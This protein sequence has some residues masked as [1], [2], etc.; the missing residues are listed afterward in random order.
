MLPSVS[1]LNNQILALQPVGVEVTGITNLVNVIATYLN[2]MQ[3]GPTGAPGIFTYNNAAAIA[4]L[5]SLPNVA[6]NSWITPFANGIHAGTT[7]AILVP[8]TITSPAWTV[9]AVDIGPVS[10]PTLSAALSALEGA[11][12]SVTSSND[13]AMPLAQAINIYALAFTFLTIGISGTIV[14]PV[15]LPLT[16]PAQ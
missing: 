1:S 8:G 6:D 5:E 10:I 14:S 2:Q 13:P 7:A 11:L 3:G 15:P 12:G 4:A 9:S 16:F